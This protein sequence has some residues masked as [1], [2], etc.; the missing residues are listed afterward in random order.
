[1]ATQ[2]L[3]VTA[4]TAN[5][6]LPSGSCRL[7]DGDPVSKRRSVRPTRAAVM[8]SVSISSSSLS[9]MGGAR[10]LVPSARVTH[11]SAQPLASMFSMDSSS[12]SRC[13]A[14]SPN[15]ASWIAWASAVSSS[16]VGGS[17]PCSSCCWA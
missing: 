11:T 7:S 12:S 17:R 14:P 13:S 1:M 15:S 6:R 16:N 9:A 8:R 10:C 3:D 4:M 5:S 2:G